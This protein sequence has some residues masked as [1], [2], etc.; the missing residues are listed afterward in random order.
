MTEKLLDGLIKYLEDNYKPKNGVMDEIKDFVAENRVAEYFS[1]LASLFLK[2]EKSNSLSKNDSGS[3]RENEEDVVA[4][5][6]LW[7]ENQRKNN[8]SFYELLMKHLKEKGYENDYPAFYKKIMMDRRMFSRIASARYTGVP[9][10]ETVFKLVIGL[11]LDLDNSN[12]MLESVGHQF[13]CYK[14]TDMIVKYCIEK[15]VYKIET[16]DDFLVKFGEKALFSLA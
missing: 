8:K 16:V 9:E 10:K 1:G 4:D 12:D 5:L 11:E 13:N 6:E 15:Q 2:P 7:L 14:K 3:E